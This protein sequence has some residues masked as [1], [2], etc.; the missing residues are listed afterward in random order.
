MSCI[1]KA[2]RKRTPF[3]FLKKKFS[4]RAG[5]E[6]ALRKRMFF[7]F[8]KEKASLQANAFE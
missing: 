6:K 7:K 2:S 5:I 3:K 1:E 4:L 8:L